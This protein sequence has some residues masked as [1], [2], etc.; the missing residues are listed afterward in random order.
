MQSDQRTIC[1]FR[2]QMRT[3]QATERYRDEYLVKEF[4]HCWREFTDQQAR[5]LESRRQRI[6]ID[7]RDL[8]FQDALSNPFYSYMEQAFDHKKKHDTQHQLA[9]R[10]QKRLVRTGREQPKETMRNDSRRGFLPSLFNLPKHY[11]DRQISLQ[12]RYES[13][14]D[15]QTLPLSSIVLQA[16]DRRIFIRERLKFLQRSSSM[17]DEQ[18]IER[19]MLQRRLI[20]HGTIQELD[21]LIEDYF[22]SDRRRQSFLPAIKTRTSQSST[23]KENFH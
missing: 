11:L 2:N 14:M 1:L 18:N 20:E 17:N 12:R 16:E 10:M 7:F 22:T 6:L 3:K 4:F 8:W 23:T 15:D 19:E 21:Q 9:Y 13:M 5:L